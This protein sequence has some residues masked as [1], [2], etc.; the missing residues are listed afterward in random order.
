VPSGDVVK[1]LES[2]AS[3]KELSYW[4]EEEK[5]LRFIAHWTLLVCSLLAG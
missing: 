5:A 4:E 1:P 3:L 2:E